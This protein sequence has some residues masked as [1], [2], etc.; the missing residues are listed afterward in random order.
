ML[1]DARGQHP[2]YTPS[3]PRARYV[4]RAR[5]QCERPRPPAT[6]AI[7]RTSPEA[8]TLQHLTNRQGTAS[9]TPCARRNRSSGSVARRPLPRID[10]P[11][12]RPLGLR[13]RPPHHRRPPQDH[14]PLRLPHSTPRPR[15]ATPRPGLRAGRH[16]PRRPPDRGGVPGGLARV[17]GANAQTDNHGPLHRLRPQGSISRPGHDPPRGP[18]PP[19]RRQLRTRS[20][21]HRTRP[22]HAA[23]VRGHPVQRAHRRRLPAPPHS[24]SRPL[25]QHPPPTP[26]AN[27][28]AGHPRKLRRSSATVPPCATRSRSSTKSSSEPGCAEAKHSPCT[29]PTST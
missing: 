18:H 4:R 3:R 21:R 25:R 22:R 9:S 6:T 5:S 27:A 7:R 19:P 10:Q 16:P 8:K 23:P 24:Q 28:P 15:R 14:A 13:R 26:D 1:L 12:P 17:Q 11:P 2:S 20:A 29:G